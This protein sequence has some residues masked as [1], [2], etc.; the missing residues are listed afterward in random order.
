M[1][2][3]GGIVAVVFGRGGL[4]ARKGQN[5]RRRIALLLLLLLLDAGLFLLLVAG[6]LD[7]DSAVACVVGRRHRRIS[8]LLLLGGKKGEM[9]CETLAYTN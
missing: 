3:G 8:L 9:G 7:L 5:N 6:R 2:T 4:R 1:A